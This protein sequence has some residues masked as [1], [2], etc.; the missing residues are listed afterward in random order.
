[1]K[2]SEEQLQKR[3]EYDRKYR[4]GNPAA[5]RAVQRKAYLKRNFGITPERYTEL[6]QSQNSKCA[7]CHGVQPSGRRLAVDHCH[8]TGKVRGLLCN[9]CNTA[10]GLLGDDPERLRAAVSYLERSRN[11]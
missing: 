4:R 7:I 10:I 8:D 1:M 2:H 6:E 3:R 5:V 11:H 9:P